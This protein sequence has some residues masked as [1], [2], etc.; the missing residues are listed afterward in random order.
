MSDDPS[1]F[2][3]LQLESF[4][5]FFFSNTNNKAFDTLTQRESFKAFCQ[6]E[7]GLGAFHSTS[8]SERQWPCYWTLLTVKFIRR[9]FS[10]I[11]K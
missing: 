2:D 8:G 3:S 6:S 4:D 5:A 7:R 10:R 1:I 11:F 9:P